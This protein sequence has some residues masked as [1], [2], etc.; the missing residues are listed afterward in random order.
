MRKIVLWTFVLAF[1]GAATVSKVLHQ[2]RA[3]FEAATAETPTQADM[4]N[5]NGGI[6]MLPSPALMT[7][8]YDC[9]PLDQGLIR[10]Q[11][12]FPASGIVG[13]TPGVFVAQAAVGDDQTCAG[14][15]QELSNLARSSGC[16]TKVMDVS[17]GID[18]RLICERDSS[19]LIHTMGEL[20][21]FVI[22]R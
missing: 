11:I 13:G 20:G 6:R 15:A 14:I 17:N 4:L 21:R 3:G 8:Y 22:T 1:V 10:H 2:E 18:L 5:E 12:E 7:G 19:S 16:V 9:S